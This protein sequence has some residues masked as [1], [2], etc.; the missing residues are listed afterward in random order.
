MK[1]KFILA[2][3]F[4]IVFIFGIQAQKNEKEWARIY[5][6]GKFGIISKSGNEI[7]KPEFDLIGNFNNKIAP[8]VKNGEVYSINE[9]GQR[10]PY[11]PEIKG[12]VIPFAEEHKWGLKTR[13]HPKL[14]SQVERW[15]D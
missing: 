3:L 4:S 7:V 2:V 9:N 14:K 5:V 12:K 1:M 10:L 8:V 13:T 15:T 11:N 6:N